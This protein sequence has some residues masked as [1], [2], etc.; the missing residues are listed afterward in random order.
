[1][2]TIGASPAGWSWEAGQAGQGNRLFLNEVFWVLRTGAPWR[3]LPPDYGDWNNTRHRFCR[4]RDRGVWKELL[5]MVIDDPDYEWLMGGRRLRRGSSR[6]NWGSWRQPGG[7]PHKR[8]LNSKLRLAA[9]P[10]GMPVRMT[11]TDGTTADCT[12]GERQGMEP[13]IPPRRNRKEPRDYDRVLYKLRHL[14]E[15]VF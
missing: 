2:A 13:V 9:D 14:V 1:M 12:Q 8:G 11:L 3:D 6:R 5:D 4:W 10:H 7:R 15:N